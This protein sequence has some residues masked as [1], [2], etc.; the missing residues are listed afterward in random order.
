[1]GACEGSAEGA[2]DGAADGA[3][4]GEAVGASVGACVVFGRHYVVPFK[5]REYNAKC[6][7]V[8][9]DLLWSPS[10]ERGFTIK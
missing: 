5:W 9:C 3:L 2:G 10:E 4:D 1:M 7:R 6:I 8:H